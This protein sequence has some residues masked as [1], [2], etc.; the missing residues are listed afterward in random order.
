MDLGKILVLFIHIEI[1]VFLNCRLFSQRIT[2]KIL[3]CVKTG[4]F[5][6]SQQPSFNIKDNL[7]MYYFICFYISAS[8]N[9]EHSLRT[10]G[11]SAR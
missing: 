8:I 11:S 7:M 3:V 10:S 2:S 1:T 5:H 9:L 4:I 6:G